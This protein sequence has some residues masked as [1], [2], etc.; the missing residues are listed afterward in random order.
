MAAVKRVG[1]TG[2]QPNPAIASKESVR[3]LPEEYV[4]PISG[5]VIRPYGPSER[6]ETVQDRRNLEIPVGREAIALCAAREVA[7]ARGEGH[8]LVPF[9][10]MLDRGDGARLSRS[11]AKPVHTDDSKSFFEKTKREWPIGSGNFMGGVRPVT[12]QPPFDDPDPGD[13]G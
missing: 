13:I 5:K 12:T 2:Y 6:R 4:S 8:T 1:M 7:R 10:E 9:T 11:P 3:P